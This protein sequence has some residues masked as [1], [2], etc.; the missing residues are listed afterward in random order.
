MNQANQAKALTDVSDKALSEELDRRARRTGSVRS[1]R[2]EAVFGLGDQPRITRRL[3][4]RLERRCLSEGP[5]YSKIVASVARS[6]KSAREPAKYF[7]SVVMRR[8]R[9]HGYE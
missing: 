5:G 7:A 3:Y 9:E 6:A 1:E 8:L 4:A 2:L